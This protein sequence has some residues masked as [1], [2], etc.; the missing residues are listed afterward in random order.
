VQVH[1][2]VRTLGSLLDLDPDRVRRAA[3]AVAG[4]GTVTVIDERKSDATF[5]SVAAELSDPSR[6]T[7]LALMQAVADP[8]RSR[9]VAVDRAGREHDPGRVSA[10]P[11]ADFDTP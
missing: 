4:V 5:L 11:L 8:G 10:I 3:A 1:L 2:R 7:L 6:A 9:A